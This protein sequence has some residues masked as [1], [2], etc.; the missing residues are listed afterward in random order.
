MIVKYEMNICFSPCDDQHK[1]I[2]KIIQ[3]FLYFASLFG[4]KKEKE[5]FLFAFKQTERIVMVSRLI[6]VVVSFIVD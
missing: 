3:R 6:V 1:N 5:F 2:L 4:K